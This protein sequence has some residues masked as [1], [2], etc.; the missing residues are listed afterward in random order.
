MQAAAQLSI[1][2]MQHIHCQC[3]AQRNYGVQ[4]LPDRLRL[5][6]RCDGLICTYKL[7]YCWSCINML[8]GEHLLASQSC[9]FDVSSATCACPCCLGQFSAH[10]KANFAL[11]ERA[12]ELTAAEAAAYIACRPELACLVSGDGASAAAFNASQWRVEA[13]EEGKINVVYG[14]HGPSGSLLVKQAP[15]Y[16]RSVGRSFPLS[17]VRGSQLTQL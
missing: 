9:C 8:S 1:G 17:Q 11:L 13:I 15:P 2:Q 16:V 12:Q 4:Q 5:T 6:F 10:L 7:C 3:A 14:V